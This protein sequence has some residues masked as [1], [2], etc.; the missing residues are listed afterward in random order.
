MERE[1][2]KKRIAWRLVGVSGFLAV[3]L[4]AFGAH[5]LAAHLDVKAFDVFRTAVSYQFY[6]TF[7]MALCLLLVEK[8][9]SHLITKAFWF[10]G[11]GVVV[12]SGS[13]YLYVLSGVKFFAMLTPIGGLCF[14]V[15]WGLLIVAH[16]SWTKTSR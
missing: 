1:E 9:P 13:L 10:F 3:L 6:H 7:A 2:L 16:M 12:F 15:G 14:L 5:A 11:T 4:G 8:N